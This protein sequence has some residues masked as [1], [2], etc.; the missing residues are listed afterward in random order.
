MLKR[1][2]KRGRQDDA[3]NVDV[4]RPALTGAV[5]ERLAEVTDRVVVVD[6]ETTGVYPSDRVVE[7]AAVT[8]DLTGRVVDEWDTLVNPQRDVGPTWLHGISPSMVTDAPCFEDIAAALAARLHGAVI[9][10]HNLPFDARMLGGEFERSGVDVTF[11][12]LDTLSVTRGKLGVVCADYGISLT[13]A[14][15]AL[16]D[17]RATAQLLLCT[18]QHFSDEVTCTQ[19]HTPISEVGPVRLRARAGEWARTQAPPTWFSELAARV[20]HHSAGAD[21]VTYLDVLDRAMADLHLD[22]DE[23]SLLDQLA[24]DLG[25]DDAQ[26]ARAHRRW[27]VDAIETACEDGVV[28]DDEYDQLLRA[29]HVLAVDPLL[30]E[31]RTVTHRT[32]VTSVELAPGTGVWFTGAASNANGDPV[33]R[34]DL[35]A[36]AESIGLVAAGKFTKST[37][38][39]LVAADPSSQS[40]KAANARKWGIPIIGVDAF[41]TATGTGAIVTGHE[42]AV[43]GREALTCVTC[44]GTFTR[45]RAPGRRPSDCDACRGSQA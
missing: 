16:M 36:H 15:T 29:A 21:I 38:G 33:R 22:Q 43:G 23:R 5:L 28:D 27:L 10:A 6:T 34:E 18:L 13:D 14:H 40:G 1:W 39:L 44:G 4:A 26:I 7:I 3:P 24:H 19:C 35:A 30:I 31:Q 41:L 2:Q 12:G 8:L 45:D 32:A 42:V 37:C 25:L 11:G 20:S 17:A 9:C